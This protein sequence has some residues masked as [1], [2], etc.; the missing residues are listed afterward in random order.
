MNNNHKER[1]VFRADASVL[2]GGGQV[3]RCLIIADMLAGAG[4]Q[5]GIACNREALDIIPAAGRHDLLLLDEGADDIAAMKQ[6]WPG[7]WDLAV[8]DHY[9][10]DSGFES[11]LRDHAEKIF[12]VDDIHDRPHDCDYLFDQAH[13]RR[14]EEYSNLVPDNCRFLLGTDYALLRNEFRNMRAESLRRGRD[15]RNVRRVFVS[16]GATDRFN[17]AGR[18]LEAIESLVDDIES[19]V[20]LGSGAPHIDAVR[21]KA[22][23]MNKRVNVHVD[24]DQVA[25][26]MTRADLAL[27]SPGITSWERCCLGV[28]A[29]IVPWADNQKD[30]AEALERIGAGIHLGWE[31][32]VTAGVIASALQEVIDGKTRLDDMSRAAAGACDGRGAIRVAM[33]LLSLEPGEGGEEVTLRLADKTDGN[34]LL[35]WRQD[36][37]VREYFRVKEKPSPEEHRKWLDS[38]LSDPDR[39]LM[40]IIS[41]DDDAGSVRL[42]GQSDGSYEISIYIDPPFF[43]RGLA[44]AALRLLRKLWPGVSLVADV[45]PENTASLALFKKCGFIRNSE[46]KF[47]SQ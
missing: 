47:I 11:R 34:T 29:L 7:H 26:L 23:Q 1:A 25:T 37:H 13:G 44:T 16:F 43:K 45:L 8:V 2:I 31:S 41:G 22:S 24:T 20:V 30:N 5:C 42:D 35:R 4:W 6:K 18:A 39:Y 40:M 14:R 10:L 28:P 38:C 12:V 17:L 19:D 3:M 46:G 27:G 36:C 15:N 32:D 21:Q 9:G 33:E